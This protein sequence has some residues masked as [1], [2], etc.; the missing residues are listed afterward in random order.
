VIFEEWRKFVEK[1]GISGSK[2]SKKLLLMKFFSNAQKFS[3]K[4]KIFHKKKT[5]PPGTPSKLVLKIL[6]NFLR[7]QVVYFDNKSETEINWLSIGD[8]RPGGNVQ[9]MTTAFFGLF[10]AK[11]CGPQSDECFE[12]VNFGK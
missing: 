5:K 3:L 6:I 7:L 9:R 1:L 2:K 11:K 8:A 10:G 12:E 4:N